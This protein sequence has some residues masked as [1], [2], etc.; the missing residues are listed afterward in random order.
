MKD[1][2][3]IATDIEIRPFLTK[4]GFVTVAEPGNVISLSERIDI[5]F[6]G[7]GIPSTL[8]VLSNYFKENSVDRVLQLGFAGAFIKDLQPG[9]MIEVIEDSFGDLGFDDKGD[10]LPMHRLAWYLTT[11]QNEY[12]DRQGTQ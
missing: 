3:V 7:I 1:L 8:L 6:S 2:I 11:R 4:N 5:L 9:D 12:A 10:F